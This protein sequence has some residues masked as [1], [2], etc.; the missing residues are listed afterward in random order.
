MLEEKRDSA[1]IDFELNTKLQLVALI[2][3]L[4]TQANS[5]GYTLGEYADTAQMTADAI[6][7]C[8]LHSVI[9][10]GEWLKAKERLYKKLEKKIKKMET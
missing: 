5:Q 1:I 10:E 7:T 4:E 6:N 9:T 8:Y 2:K 3:D